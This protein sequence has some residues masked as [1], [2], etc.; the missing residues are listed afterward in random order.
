MC[1]RG[2]MTLPAHIRAYVEEQARR[3]AES[4]GDF[5]VI[6]DDTSAALLKEHLAPP[7]LART[8]FLAHEEVGLD[9][10]P[11]AGESVIVTHSDR[12]RAH[13]MHR[14]LVRAKE[15]R[16]VVALALC[17]RRL[18]NQAP[19]WEGVGVTYGGIFRLAATYAESLPRG[20]YA[21][22]G[23]FDGHTFAIAFHALRN[24]C[25]RFYA[26][27]SYAGIR[28]A[29]ESETGKY[30]DGDYFANFETF[31]AN[32]RLAKVDLKRVTCVR[33]SFQ[34]TLR[35]APSEHQLG[36]VSVAHI[37]VDVYEPA[38]L[39]LDYLSSVL[40]QGALVLFDDYDQMGASNQRGER[41]AIK[42]WLAENPQFALEPYRN[43]A[44]FG[45]SFIFDRG[46]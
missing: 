32:M 11:K 38:K 17:D 1:E 30:R 16:C 29:M 42:E 44:T 6:A 27:D 2:G 28:G 20:S 5:A 35:K 36:P 25:E 34:E 40:Q 31:V 7:L 33:G 26:Y 41:R 22:F 24:T 4:L 9:F 23:V 14:R 45:R 10:L 3:I 12:A 19:G 37:D 15:A 39:A 13:Q 21:E 43:Y 46:E 8:R 18:Q